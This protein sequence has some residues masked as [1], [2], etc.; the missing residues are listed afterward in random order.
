MQVIE[1][2]RVVV[3]VLGAVEQVTDQSPVFGH[4][5]PKGVVHR[6]DRG[7]AVNVGA[8]AAGTLRKKICVPW[9]PALEHYLESSEKGRTAPRVCH[10]PILHFHFYFEVTLNPGDRVY[11]HSCHNGFSLFEKRIIIFLSSKCPNRSG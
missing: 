3:Q 9:V 11:Y 8:N 7:Q 5:C 2:H 4:V 1:M 6:A 10:F